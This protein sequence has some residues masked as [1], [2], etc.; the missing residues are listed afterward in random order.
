M[1]IRIARTFDLEAIVEIYNQAVAAR[2]TA[3]MIPL[4]VEGSED[5]FRRHAPER[6][7]ILVADL[8][9]EV[10]GWASISEYRPGRGALRHTAEI[11]YY[12]DSAHH[13]RGV[14]SGLVSAAIDR[15]PSLAIKTLFA[16]LLADNVASVRLLE[17]LG[18]EEWGHLPRVADFDGRE[19][20]HLYYGLRVG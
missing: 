19:V 2:A 1:S 5:W 20:G 11:S 8:G 12:V 17:K 16:I 4:T 15:C 18:F 6:H 10:A 13:R 7:P 3:D 14:G 9:G